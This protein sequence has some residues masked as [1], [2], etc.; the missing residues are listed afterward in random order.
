MHINHT[1]LMA[2]CTRAPPGVVQALEPDLVVVE[3]C[4]ARVPLLLA[5]AVR[6]QDSSVQGE[7]A[8]GCYAWGW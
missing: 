1:S 7:G 8:R 6:R 4:E 5:D 2:G 3:L